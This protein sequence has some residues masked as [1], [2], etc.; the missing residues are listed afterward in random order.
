MEGAV[1][2]LRQDYTPAQV[3][4]T[5]V[6]F[7]Q[8]PDGKRFPVVPLAADNALDKAASVDRTAIPDFDRATVDQLN[9]A[10][11]GELSAIASAPTNLV[12][13]VLGHDS[14]YSASLIADARNTLEADFQ[15]GYLGYAGITPQQN[16]LLKA[17]FPTKV[18][19]ANANPAAI[20]GILGAGATSSFAGRFLNDV[21][22]TVPQ[23]AF[24]LGSLGITPSGQEAL[25]GVGVTSNKALVEL[26]KSATG[27]A[28]L[29]EAL[30]VPEATL[31]RYLETAT[32]NVAR[33][34]LITAPEKSIGT[35]AAVPP[36]VQIAL[37][38]A[39]IGSAKELANANPTELAT[40]LGFST[41]EMAAIVAVAALYG[42]NAHLT[43]VTGS[44]QGSIAPEAIA[45]AG[46]MSTGAIAQADTASLTAVGL[47][48]TTAQ[49]MQG[50]S[51]QLLASITFRRFR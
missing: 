15:N 13:G 29:Q 11:L 42:S 37:A 26:G 18:D 27:R 43:L 30:N 45:N 19:L 38:N 22:A 33:G 25:A 24:N 47:D 23:D 8:T 12:A 5:V 16:T 3:T 9:Q 51:Q 31:N 46:L 34:E 48:T 2:Y 10:G 39:G 50:L 49:Q 21:R 17:A 35:L 20:A 4:D 44:A 40:I 28:Q 41:A 32:L 14:T 7:T 36:D 1:I 6:A